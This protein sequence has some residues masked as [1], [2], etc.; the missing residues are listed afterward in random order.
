M[1][2]AHGRWSVCAVLVAGGA[3]AGQ[4]V[5]SWDPS[6]GNPGITDWSVTSLVA[7]DDGHGP[8]LYAGGSAPGYEVGR[9]A[10][11]DGTAWSPLGN[12]EPSFG[13]ALTVFDD[14]TG[15]ALYAAGQIVGSPPRYAV[16]RWG[17][18]AWEPVGEAMDGPVRTLYVFDDDG[19]GP[20]PPSLYAGSMYPSRVA[21]LNGQH[22]TTLGTLPSLREVHALAGFDDD[23]AGPN[24]PALYVAGWTM[25]F[26]NG[27]SVLRWSGVQ[28]EPVG[29]EALPG[30]GVDALQAWD[31]GGGLALYGIGRGSGLVKWDGLRW[32]ALPVYGGSALAVFD[33]G[34]GPALYT[35]APGRWDGSHFQ[36]LGTGVRLPMGDA[37]VNALAGFDDGRGFGESLYVGGVFAYAGGFASHNVAKW[38]S[39]HDGPRL[40]YQPPDT[41]VSA[42]R[43]VHLG[44][45]AAA[46]TSPLTYQWRHNGIALDAGGRAF[47]VDTRY[48]TINPAF[49]ADTGA[50]DVVVTNGC[51][52]VTSRTAMLTVIC[53]ADF[54]ADGA[55]TVSDYLAFLVAFAA[56]DPRADMDGSGAVD[57]ADARAFFAAYA[58]GC[59]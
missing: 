18:L 36:M 11:W 41:T 38:T 51:R 27:G 34:S 46:S 28:W 17:G 15:P 52:S 4:C 31:D 56:A 44:V 45:T 9:V 53:R 10:R 50:Y 29:T 1:A 3:A 20:N 54:T 19:A 21:R 25:D 33:D 48:L 5:F 42:G 2:F 23:G 35:G 49:M 37:S 55:L 8:A 57:A 32:M 12:D 13:K 22:W 58:G 40:T 6:A 26:T 7:F 43:P 30:W 47:G 59:P 16:A 24:P 39:E 14:G